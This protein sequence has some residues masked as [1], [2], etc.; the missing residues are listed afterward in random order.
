MRWA[1]AG[2]LLVMALAGCGSDDTARHS[3]AANAVEPTLRSIWSE[4][5]AGLEVN[6]DRLV[7][8]RKPDASLD[9]F[10]REKVEDID[11]EFRDAPYSLDD[12]EPLVERVR[13]DWHYWADRQVAI[14]TVTPLADGTAVNAVVATDDL[15]ATRAE[16]RNRYGD[17][18]IVVHL[19][20][21][22]GIVPAQ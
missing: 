12:L 14:K 8:Y 18:P 9:A 3:A 17:E 4:S 5:F 20:T 15:D 19:P 7:I 16:F 10:V 6:D 13:A 22:G 2:L 11:V 21:R 1:V